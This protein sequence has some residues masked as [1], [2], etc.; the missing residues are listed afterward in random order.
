MLLLCGCTNEALY[1][2]SYP[3]PVVVL[4]DENTAYTINGYKDTTVSTQSQ[5]SSSSTNSSIV[6]SAYN[7]KYI[8]NTNTKKLHKISCSYIKNTSEENIEIFDN[9]N[10]AINNGY[11]VCKRCI[12]D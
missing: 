4:P 1:D 8:G 10:S 6:N 7:G 12:G 2:V 9:V 5:N 3:K 11:S